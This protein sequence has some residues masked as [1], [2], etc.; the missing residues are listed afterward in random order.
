YVCI[1]DYAAKELSTDDL[2]KILGYE[3]KVKICEITGA[4]CSEC[5]P[6]CSS[7]EIK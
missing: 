4:K 3:I 5:I 6:V 7:W 2:M 1:D